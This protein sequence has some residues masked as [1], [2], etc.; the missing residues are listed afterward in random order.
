MWRTVM[1]LEWR[2]MRRDRAA[3]AVLALF[4]GCL[5]LAAV[6]GG[7][8]ADRHAAGVERATAEV[9][10][11][12]A[13]HRAEIERRGASPLTAA[14]P[15]DPVWMGQ[16]GAARVAA[17]PPA[18]LASV[19]VG[20]RD[21][22]PQA[23]RIS[24]D[25]NLTAERET[26]TPMAGPGQ[27]MT[28]AF[29]PA[30]LFVV[31]FPLV[32]I[33]LSYEL[34]SG[35]RERGTLAMLL[36][37]PISQRGLVLGKAGA[38]AIGLC[39]VTVLAA[40]GGLLIA[41]ASPL[42]G[43]VEVALYGAVLVAWAAFW[44]AAAVAVASRGGS[45]AHSALVLV[46]GWLVL[47]VIIP[48]LL[49]AAVDTLYPPPDRMALVHEARAA[50]QEAERELA[51]LEG[52]HDRDPQSR[53]VTTRVVAVQAAL[54][55]RTEPVLAEMRARVRE[56]HGLIEALRFLSPA[57]VVQLAL[58]DVAGSG[59]TRHHRF[60]VQVDRYHADWRAWFA[61]RVEA[62]S[63]LAAAD[64]DALPRFVYEEEPAAALVA[65]VG[66]GVAALWGLTALLIGLAL[67]GL[68][69]VGRLGA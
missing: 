54:V 14:D 12:L 9:A 39:A 66:A 60:E 2:L 20:Q 57:L 56:R 31:L 6:A 68:R 42:A 3:L 4:A 32:I 27:L 48:G 64:V 44:F 23:V 1:K 58:E 59:A 38:R 24:T 35:D 40:L 22:H 37:Q 21:L 43:G 11:R 17:L 25:V 18:P 5:A 8:H 65:R 30:F 19:A 63:R 47:V 33:A 49:G 46:G 45:S 36:S 67:P 34:L 69:R 13:A 53:D 28:G 41:G 26:E 55:E 15:R 50:A 16:D 29:D 61:E 62:G 51:G 52:R 7:R 10:A